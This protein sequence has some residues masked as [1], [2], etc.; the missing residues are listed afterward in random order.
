[1]CSVALDSSFDGVIHFDGVSLW[2]KSLKPLT[3]ERILIVLQQVKYNVPST[4]Y[5]ITYMIADSDPLQYRYVA[6]L[7]RASQF[8]RWVE[9]GSFYFQ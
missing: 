4:K 7:C 1:M 8:E 3:P 9:T 5:I 2:E 6:A